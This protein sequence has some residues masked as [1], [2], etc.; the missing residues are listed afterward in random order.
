MDSGI[1]DQPHRAEHLVVKA[2]KAVVGI[3][4]DA[5]LFPEAF[6]IE[7]PAFGIGCI[8][9]ETHEA[10]KSLIFLRKADLEMMAWNGLVEIKRFAFGL[11]TRRKII[12]V[13]V[14]DAGPRSVRRTGI[15]GT[16]SI[17]LFLVIRNR[18][19]LKR[20]F[21]DRRELFTDAFVN[22]LAN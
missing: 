11:R 9:A 6:C 1:D 22:F 5:Q 8:A 21:R 19:N 13:V 4:F 7:R 15:I 2:T 17:R 20:A 16:A 10:G 14:K 12:A 3:A 18:A